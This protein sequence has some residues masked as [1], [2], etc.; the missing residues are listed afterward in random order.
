MERE[1]AGVLGERHVGEPLYDYVAKAVPVWE[2]LGASSQVLRWIGEGV[3][4]PHRP[5]EPRRGKGAWFKPAHS[6]YWEETLLPKYL[7]S[8]ALVA[9]ENENAAEEYL[10]SVFLVAKRT[11]GYRLIVDMRW[12]NTYFDPPPMQYEGLNMLKHA[13][14]D[15]VKGFSIDL[16][17][18]YHHFKVHPTLQRY[19]RI[20]VNGKVWVVKGMPFGWN[21]APFIFTTCMRVLVKAIRHPASIQ[22]WLAKELHLAQKFQAGLWAI[23][24][25][26]DLACLVTQLE[27][28]RKV[29]EAV[30]QLYQR[31]HLSFNREKSELQLL[32]SFRHLG[33]WVDVAS[34]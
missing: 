30:L 29:V 12:F 2:A 34:R 4:F 9:A 27:A 28:A 22:P 24:Y 14:P 7:A 10:S 3:D 8:G 5:I 6:K 25:L 13:P 20:K 31:M 26:D 15:V 17:D 33:F 18:G 32:S 16:T 11:G 1:H 19:F 23:M 21:V